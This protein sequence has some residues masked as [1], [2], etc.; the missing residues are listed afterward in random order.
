MNVTDVP[1]QIAPAGL[2]ATETEGVTDG[3]TV[4][5]IAEEVAVDGEGH[6]ALLVMTTVTLSLFASVVDVNVD[7]VAPPTFD[8]L[9]CH[10]YVGVVPPFVG[11]A[12]NVTD[13]PAQ[14][15]PA[16][17]AAMETEGVTV[18]FTVIV[19][20]EEVAVADV[21]QATLLVITTVTTFPFVSV[22]DVNVDEVAPPTFDPL[23]CH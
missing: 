6:V 8:P 21:G 1:A 5:V 22:E 19:I 4:I 16:G 10:W 14:I 17:L 12:V 23:I 11:V 9:I 2:A 15:A 3:F 13:V 7:E 18:G 20:P